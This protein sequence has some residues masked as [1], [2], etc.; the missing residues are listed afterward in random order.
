MNYTYASNF[1]EF[2]FS[3]CHS[4]DQ[5]VSVADDPMVPLQGIQVMYFVS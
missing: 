1:T 4:F 2:V 3:E 5:Q